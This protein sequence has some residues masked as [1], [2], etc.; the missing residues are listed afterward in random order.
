[1]NTRPAQ[2]HAF[3]YVQQNKT[4]KN[5]HLVYFLLVILPVASQ[6]I[7]TGTLTKNRASGVV[8]TGRDATVEV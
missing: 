1:M 3:L 7:L 4:T 8:G 5:L 2:L 6:D